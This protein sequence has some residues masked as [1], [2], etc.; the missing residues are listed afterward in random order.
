MEKFSELLEAI[1]KRLQKKLKKPLRTLRTALYK[2]LIEFYTPYTGTERQTVTVE[3]LSKGI[4]EVLKKF[5]NKETVSP[6]I[7]K[8][9]PYFSEI[10]EA[11]KLY[12][13]GVITNTI[14]TASRAATIQRTTELLTKSIA[15]DM[16]A[17]FRRVSTVAATT[18][19]NLATLTRELQA[20]SGRVQQYAIQIARDAVY[21]H[22]REVQAQI[23][24]EY[25]YNGYRYTG[26]LLNDS[27]PACKYIVRVLDRKVL[28]KDLPKLVETLKKSY[29]QGLYKNL[30][31]EKFKTTCGGYN[32]RHILIATNY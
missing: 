25:G 22:Q 5:F 29:P 6:I 7:E 15:N 13:E 3:I 26:S 18:D 31:V 23:A 27:R 2:A 16:Q 19:V 10:T 32:C 14:A 11:S 1:I 9:I 4:K 21:S 17:V 30:T 24:K 12:S 20:R 8:L 28:E